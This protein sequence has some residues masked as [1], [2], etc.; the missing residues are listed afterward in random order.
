M[1]DEKL[2]I[3]T[4][5]KKRIDKL[6]NEIYLIM[7][8]VP[9]VRSNLSNNKIRGVM[10]KIKN[11]YLMIPKPCEEI[12]LELSNEDCRALIDIRTAERE[13]LQQILKNIN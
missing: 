2:E 5:I 8:I 1:T 3:A 12:A 10:R 4:D 7:D 9:A 13:V 11:R 6:D